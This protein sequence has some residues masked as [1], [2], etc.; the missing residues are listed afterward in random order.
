MEMRRCE[1]S[2]RSLNLNS[3]MSACTQN[4]YLSKIVVKPEDLFH[5][6][7]NDVPLSGVFSIRSL[8]WIATLAL[9]SGYQSLHSV[10][11][12]RLLVLENR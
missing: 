6:M 7:Q 2:S 3:F 10:T 1:F 5:L 9:V 12:T 8:I 4:T 11:S